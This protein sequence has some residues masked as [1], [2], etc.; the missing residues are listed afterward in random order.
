MVDIPTWFVHGD[1]DTTQSVN[2]AASAIT[3]F[4]ALAP[5]PVIPPMASFIKS[6]THSSGVWTTEL[7]NKSTAKFNFEEWL[8]MHSKN[9]D[10]TATKYVE[11]LESHVSAVNYERALTVYLTA[12]TLV[13]NLPGDSPVKTNLTTR[14]GAALTTI[15]GSFAKRFVIDCGPTVSSGNVNSILDSNTGTT[16]S[17]IIDTTGAA[18]TYGFTMVSNTWW[19]TTSDTLDNLGLNNN[20][21]GLNENTFQDGFRCS[22]AGTG[23]MRFTGLNP[24][25]TY[26][27][28]VFGSDDLTGA[29][30][31]TAF[32]ELTVIQ[33]TEA[34]YIWASYNTK[35]YIQYTN[36]TPTGGGQLNFNARTGWN[37]ST[38]TP[39]YDSVSGSYSHPV[40][41]LTGTYRD[42]GMVN[43]IILVENP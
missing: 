14:Y 37:V 33:G 28:I 19:T 17:N 18:S 31:N 15:N 38:G 40:A 32:P 4:N 12:K 43:A 34:K 41:N 13:D 39:T 5:K 26:N 9:D 42:F 10:Y 21:C 20:Y 6:G 1:A 8:L 23:S 2:N 24:A 29:G 11:K 35:N 30:N 36:L 16:L 25:K 3:A 22:G 27:L 7:Y